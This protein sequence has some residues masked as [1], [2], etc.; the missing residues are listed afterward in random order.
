MKPGD[1]VCVIY[2]TRVPFIV[3]SCEQRQAYEFVGACY[4]DEYMD[5]EAITAGG[6]EETWIEL[7]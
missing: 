1:Q 7:V 5:G 4:I 3:R 2:G 6:C